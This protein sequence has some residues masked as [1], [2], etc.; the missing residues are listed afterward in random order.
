MRTHADRTLTALDQFLAHVGDT[1]I[2][3]WRPVIRDEVRAA[4]AEATEQDAPA[5]LHKILGT[6]ADAARKRA[7]RDPELAGLGYRVGK[8]FLYRPSDVNALLARRRVATPS[9][10]VVEGDR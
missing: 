2:E 5:P 8:R 1:L 4:L 7:Q 9:L 3:R 10:R 6:T